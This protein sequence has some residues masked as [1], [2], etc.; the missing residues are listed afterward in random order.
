MLYFP[1]RSYSDILGHCENSRLSFLQKNEQFD[2]IALESCY[3]SPSTDNALRAV[4][5]SQ[6]PEFCDNVLPEDDEDVDLHENDE[7][8]SHKNFQHENVNNHDNLQYENVNISQ[9]SN[10]ESEL[11]HYT[12]CDAS[13][14]P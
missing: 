13:E 6:L 12:D 3:S 1:H 2:K 5:L 7:Q 9:K 8:I 14:Y 4:Q 11:H 10:F